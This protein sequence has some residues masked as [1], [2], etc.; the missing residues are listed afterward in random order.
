MM[1]GNEV[2]SSEFSVVA[3]AGLRALT[4]PT[5]IIQDGGK[6][7]VS[8]AVLEYDPGKA[9]SPEQRD[10]VNRIVQ[11]FNDSQQK[12]PATKVDIPRVLETC[13]ATHPPDQIV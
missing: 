8:A 10:G 7:Y 3:K 11:L 9:G 5:F 4:G 13:Q 12:M 2:E 6:Y 1:D